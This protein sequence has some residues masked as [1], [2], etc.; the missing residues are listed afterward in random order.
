MQGICTQVSLVAWLSDIFLS[1]ELSNTIECFNSL[2]N[3]VRM[4]YRHKRLH[5]DSFQVEL[6]VALV[7]DI[8]RPYSGAG[9]VE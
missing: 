4:E 8:P 2:V 3:S 7:A 5:R 6:L 9:W 1:R